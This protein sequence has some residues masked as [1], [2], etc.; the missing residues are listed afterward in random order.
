MSVALQ[1]VVTT[2]TIRQN[3]RPMLALFVA[4]QF[5]RNHAFRDHLSGELGALAGDHAADHA[6]FLTSDWPRKLAGVLSDQYWVLGA[7]TVGNRFYTSDTP[8]VGFTEDGASGKTRD[9]FIPSGMQLG[10]PLA[11]TMLLRIFERHHFAQH[12]QADGTLHQTTL[13]EVQGSNMVQ[14]CQSEALVLADVD[15]FTYA[16]PALP[17]CL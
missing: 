11:P 10:L 15:D 1:N 12:R 3:D 2:R 7:S 14:V 8:V 4:I 9:G 5:C 13:G 17:N 16:S 6:A